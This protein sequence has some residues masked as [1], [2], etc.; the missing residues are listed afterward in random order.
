MFDENSIAKVR[1]NDKLNFIDTNGKLVSQQ[2][3]DDIY[4]YTSSFYIVKLNNKFN[5]IDKNGKLL[6]KHW[7]NSFDE[8]YDYLMGLQ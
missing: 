3:F 5:L 6:S 1:L 7:F 8:A 2:W 4:N